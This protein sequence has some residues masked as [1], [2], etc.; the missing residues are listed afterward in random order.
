MKNVRK[1][2]STVIVAASLLFAA[3]AS[4]QSEDEIDPAAV[5]AAVRY[6]LP[7]AF[8]GYMTACFETLDAGGFVTMNAPAL[9][10][11]FT[12]GAEASWPGAREFMVQV[13]Q[14]EGA[15]E[16]TVEEISDDELRAALDPLIETMA[17]TEIKPEY[18]SDIETALEIM[19]P[20]PADNLAAMFGFMMDLGLRPGNDEGRVTGPI[21]LDSYEAPEISESRARKLREQEE[22]ATEDPK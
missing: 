12:D 14:E 7:L 6:A 17:A 19:D 2:A 15:F 22:A 16:G 20:L 4:A 13:A 9:R 3:P 5:S 11:K 18:C 1:M 10:A 8:E 21:A